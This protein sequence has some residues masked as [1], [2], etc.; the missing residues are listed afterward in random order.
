MIVE[1]SWFQLAFI[2]VLFCWSIISILVIVAM[3]RIISRKDK[4]IEM[5]LSQARNTI[6][7]TSEALASLESASEQVDALKKTMDA[8]KK[9]S[10]ATKSSQ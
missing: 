7:K 5:L 8:L 9:E 2:L 4:I 3:N 6:S 10:G 1:L